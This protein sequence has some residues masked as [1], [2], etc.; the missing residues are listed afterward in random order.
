MTAPRNSILGRKPKVSVSAGYQGT[1]LQVCAEDLSP[2]PAVTAAAPATLKHAQPG[3]ILRPR[4]WRPAPL[5]LGSGYPEPSPHGLP[6]LHLL[7][8]IAAEAR[9]GAVKPL[10]PRQT[11]WV[12]NPATKRHELPK[13]IAA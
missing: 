5:P 8:A 11:G 4:G 2:L 13:E 1:P 12:W 6:A 3:T 9:L 7:G 10:R